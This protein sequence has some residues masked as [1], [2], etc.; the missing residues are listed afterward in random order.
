MAIEAY[1]DS[2]SSFITANLYVNAY[3]EDGVLL[4]PKEADNEFIEV[5]LSSEESKQQSILRIKK[6]NEAREAR[7]KAERYKALKREAWDYLSKLSSSFSIGLANATLKE[8]EI[9]GA[10]F[11][12]ELNAIVANHWDAER[13]IVLQGKDKGNPLPMPVYGVEAGR[14]FIRSGKE[15]VKFRR[16]ANPVYVYSLHRFSHHYKFAPW[17]AVT[18]PINAYLQNVSAFSEAYKAFHLGLCRL[19]LFCVENEIDTKDIR[20]FDSLE[21]IVGD[22]MFAEPERPAVW[23]T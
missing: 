14:L 4:K 20:Y 13:P 21:K 18:N 15:G 10:D 8:I 16:I 19:R 17:V 12:S 22:G 11:A 6:V 23:Y 7:Q 9:R 2:F 3:T 1:D 5:D